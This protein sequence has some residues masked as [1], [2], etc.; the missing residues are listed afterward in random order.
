LLESLARTGYEQLVLAW[1]VLLA[2]ERRVACV[3]A[4]MAAALLFAAELA[5]RLAGVFAFPRPM[6]GLLAAVESAFQLLA[7][8]FAATRIRQ[9]ARLVLQPALAAHAVFGREKR[10]LWAILAVHMT[11]VGHL[12]MAA[13]LWPPAF[14]HA[15]R[16]LRAAWQR[17]LQNRLPAIA[18]DLVK[19]GFAAGVAK[20]AVAQLLT[21]VVAAL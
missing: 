21:H 10:T 13:C 12:G 18:A 4:R 8:H 20:S 5:A 19:D 16:R 2:V 14:K 15:R 6:A 1:P 3:R 11:V 7:A 17:R 9:P